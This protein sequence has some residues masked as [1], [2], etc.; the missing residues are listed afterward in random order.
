MPYQAS[1][2]VR[3]VYVR[4]LRLVVDES[5]TVE[6]APGASGR[7]GERPQSHSPRATR[8]PGRDRAARRRGLAGSR[9]DVRRAPRKGVDRKAVDARIVLNGVKPRAIQAQEGRI[10]KRLATGRSIRTAFA[11]NSRAPIRLGF[12]I[13]KPKVGSAELDEAVVDPS[14]IEQAAVLR[15]RE[16]RSL[17]RCRDRSVRVPDADRRLRD[18]DHAAEPLVVSAAV[19]RGRR[20]R[21]RFR[22][23]RGIRWAR[24]GWGSRRRT[25]GST[26]R[27]TRPR[28]GTRP[29]TAA[30]GCASP[31]PSGSSS[32]WRSVRRS[33]SSASSTW[34]R[35]R[36]SW[37]RAW[38]S[39]SSRSSSS[40]S[41]GRC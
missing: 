28:S 26:A 25:S 2:A 16:V 37:A 15:R 31:T 8:P 29:R 30:S 12:E 24:A 38:P 34:R 23:A 40:S 6:L 3:K 11:T 9:A 35:G 7:Q 14:R 1:K 13:L 33:S 4:P 5:R 32:T 22:R 20:T 39:A 36:G 19:R 18:R 41:P 21:I 17:V 27:R 10:L